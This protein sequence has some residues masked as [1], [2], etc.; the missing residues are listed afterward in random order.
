ML[1]TWTRSEFEKELDLKKEGFRSYWR[2][3]KNKRKWEDRDNLRKGI[4]PEMKNEKGIEIISQEHLFT[5]ASYIFVDIFSKEKIL[6][7]RKTFIK[8]YC[9]KFSTNQ[10]MAASSILEIIDDH[11]K[12]LKRII[13]AGIVNDYD[14][15]LRIIKALLHNNL[16]DIPESKLYDEELSKKA[17]ILRDDFRDRFIS[18]IDYTIEYYGDAIEEED[19]LKLQNYKMNIIDFFNTVDLEKLMDKFL[20]TNTNFNKPINIDNSKLF[21]FL[22][23]DMGTKLNNFTRN[24]YKY[25]SILEKYHNFTGKR[26]GDLRKVDGIPTIYFNAI[27]DKDKFKEIIGIPYLGYL[28]HFDGYYLTHRI[29]HMRHNLKNYENSLSDLEYILEKKLIDIDL[30][31]KNSHTIVRIAV[32]N[33]DAEALKL[34]KRFNA[35]PF[36]SYAFSIAIEQKDKD[37]LTNMIKL[38]ENQDYSYLL[39]MIFEGKVETVKHLLTEQWKDLKY[40]VT[41]PEK[42]VYAIGLAVLSNSSGKLLELLNSK[43]VGTEHVRQLINIC[44]SLGYEELTLPYIEQI[45]P[46]DSS[47]GDQGSECSYI[48]FAIQQS[49]FIVA[50]KLLEKINPED[51]R[52]NKL[53]YELSIFNENQ[54]IWDKFI[55]SVSEVKLTKR[56]G[57]ESILECLVSKRKYKEINKLIPLTE[58]E[59]YAVIKEILKHSATKLKKYENDYRK[60]YFKTNNDKF[61]KEIDVIKEQLNY[62]EDSLKLLE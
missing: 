55:K 17:V 13:K 10:I 6:K 5:I 61:K 19:N 47:N 54:L 11:R 28:D 1:K 30:V 22:D 59:E 45:D 7:D 29:M 33:S 38:V 12:I 24:F 37:V 3:L 21:E 58:C 53:L 14:C 32:K 52:I 8:E 35:D 36:L 41:E 34:F 20:D 60:S 40:Y 50:E 15:L 27:H 57:I 4:I 62:I 39:K 46:L 48:A 23:S 44:I 49:C 43:I 18:S 26:T 31:D 51:E 25:I 2:R 9:K 16:Q 56:Y 42:Y